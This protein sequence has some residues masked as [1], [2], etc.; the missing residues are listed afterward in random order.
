MIQQCLV[1]LIG[2]GSQLATEACRVFVN[3]L[4]G[5]QPVRLY[6]APSLFRDLP[7]VVKC[8]AKFLTVIVI[9]Q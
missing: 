9:C 7:M 4:M 8:C 3:T 1:F 5:N 2:L 6:K